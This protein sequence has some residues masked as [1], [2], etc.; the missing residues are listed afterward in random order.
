MSEH[1]NIATVSFGPKWWRS[2]LLGSIPAALFLAALAAWGLEALLVLL[3]VTVLLTAI[4]AFN[5][6]I[7]ALLG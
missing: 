1:D 5:G 3:L 2:Q 6:L 7:R 4:G